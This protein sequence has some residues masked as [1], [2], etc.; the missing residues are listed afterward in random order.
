MR[1][2]IGLGN[3]GREYETTRHNVGF[4]VIDKLSDSL[5]I[6]VRKSKF[7][8]LYGEGMHKGEKVVLVKPM[9]YMN[10]SGHSVRQVLDWY[11]PEPE[12]WAV[13][14]DDMDLPLGTVRLRVKGSAGGHN[15]I[16][17]IISTL[18]SQEFLRVRIGIDRPDVG[19]SVVDHVLS[20]FR[21][22]QRP[23]LEDAVLKSASALRTFIEE[24]FQAAM[25]K[26]N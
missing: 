14:Y 13:V 17:S 11:K 15:G 2:V 1:I 20:P 9:T 18:G 22:E 21:K 5:G 25:N 6:E 7:Q 12:E 26:H 3:P 24:T 19:V 4:M 8:A 10:L 16:K 23:A